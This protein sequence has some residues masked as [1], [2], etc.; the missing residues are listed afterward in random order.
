MRLALRALLTKTLLRLN[1]WRCRDA[2]AAAAVGVAVGVAAAAAAAAGSWSGPGLCVEL[3]RRMS[4]GVGRDETMTV[5]TTL[6]KK[7]KRT[8]R[9]ESAKKKGGHFSRLKELSHYSCSRS[10]WSCR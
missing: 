4:C 3:A 8:R 6:K 10:R 2:A 5:I 1:S 9:R 7:K